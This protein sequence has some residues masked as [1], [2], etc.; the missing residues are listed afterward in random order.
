MTSA[1][2][3]RPKPP[4]GGADQEGGPY[5]PFAHLT[6]VNSA[7]YRQVMGV[8]V[9]AKQEFTVH[10]R[11]EDVHLGLLPEGRPPLDAVAAALVQLA[12][13]G[14]L[15]ADPD[16]GRVTAL[17][18]FY[19]ARSI[20]QLT[21]EGEAAEEALTAYD[22]SLGRRGE[23][24]A[25]A[26]A[27]IA[28]QLRAVLALARR[29]APDPA[30]VHLA[31][32][33][34]VERFSGLAE[35]A[36]A[37]MGSLQRTVDLHEA[38]VEVFLAYKQRL[39]DYLERFIADLVTRGAEIAELLEELDAPPGGAVGPLLRLAAEREAADAAP[40]AAAEALAA[41]EARWQGRWDGL[42]AWFL[43]L[44]GR[45]SQA[46]L[47][48][49]A[50][51]RAVP[52]LLAVVQALNERRAGRSDRSA[53]FRELA[54]WF[55]EA[56]DD[57]ARHRLWRS[58]FGLYSARH[59]TIDQEALAERDADPVPTSASWY[60]A[61][62]VRISPQLRRTGSYERR[63]RARAVLDRSE[64]KSY[65]AELARKQAEQTA[66][67]RARL[68][69]GGEVR[70][71]DLGVLDRDAFRLFLLLLGDAL[72]AW[73]PGTESVS[74]TTNDG[75]M[76]IRLTRLPGGGIAEIDTLDGVLWGPEHLVEIVDLA[77]AR[78][79]LGDDRA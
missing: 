55:A 19:R 4:A 46:K 26:L 54:R 52:Q 42:R 22:E 37:F 25:V 73:R 35:N 64:A 72:S 48:R 70:L 66:A 24:Q 57:G 15:R 43:S 5:R 41:A 60:D 47:L 50:A 8:F 13:W 65:L 56:P 28:A 49:S 36:R 77:P 20:Y 71:S 40:D 59:L 18:D 17:E 31:L 74:T 78:E 63:G 39:I 7:L 61:P 6:A 1:A 2:D 10:L 79:P 29:P 58:A 68:A 12:K 32:L 30:V 44:P 53:D 76:E 69:T 33:A 34:L 51:R 11:P 21:R 23:L 9:L 27:D 3:P 38:E 16:T 14:N 62:G 45:S 67:A 75:T